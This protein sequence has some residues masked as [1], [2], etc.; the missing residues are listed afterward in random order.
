MSQ[1]HPGAR[2]AS[3]NSPS[4]PE[5]AFLAGIFEFTTWAKGN[6]QVLTVATVVGAILVAGG[7]YYNS[8]RGQ[9]NTQAAQQLEV[10][11][12]S[13]SIRDTEG[14]KIDLATFLDRF[15]GTAF[16]GEARLILGELYLES[17]D[18]QQAVAVLEPLSATPREPI[19][20][21]G[22]ALL[23]VAYEQDGRWD[24]AVDVYLT[25]AARS[26]L[27]FQIRDARTA[28]A[29]IST[30]Q[31]DIDGAIEL[32]EELLAELDEN[33]PERGTYEMRIAEIRRDS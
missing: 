32:Y 8:Y 18:P 28:A 25:I 16:E 1:R 7:F 31:G 22:A 9:L 19:E 20:F 4:D 26:D 13:I 33:A 30:D 29:R 21:Q 5:D 12:Q 23:G 15:G 3:N 24:D 11:H 6:Q 14:A 17:N 10:I 2:R 27:D